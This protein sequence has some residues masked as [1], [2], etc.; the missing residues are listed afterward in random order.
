MHYRTGYELEVIMSKQAEIRAELGREA[1]LKGLKEHS[2]TGSQH[3]KLVGTL[4]RVAFGVIALSLLI[5][6]ILLT[7]STT[8]AAYYNFASTSR[9]GADFSLSHSSA[10]SYYRLLDYQ[11]ATSPFERSYSTRLLYRDIPALLRGE[12][13]EVLHYLGN[14]Q[15]NL[16][17]PGNFSLTH[18]NQLL[19]TGQVEVTGNQLRFSNNLDSPLCGSSEEATGTYTWIFDGQN[20]SLGIVSDNCFARS[21]VL[22]THPLQLKVAKPGKVHSLMPMEQ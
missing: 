7:F 4:K 19:L 14:W 2:T 16:R 9:E 20:L 1:Q 3:Y 12:M 15:L 18:N 21:L 8:H 22:T 11:T 5:V 10:N 17:E 13:P 6:A